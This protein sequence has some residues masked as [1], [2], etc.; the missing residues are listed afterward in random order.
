MI[1]IHST[2]RARRLLPYTPPAEV[3]PMAVTVSAQT[4][5]DLSRM[6]FALPLM[7]IQQ[8]PLPPPFSKR[9]NA[10]VQFLRPGLG[11]CLAEFG[12]VLVEFGDALPGLLVLGAHGVEIYLRYLAVGL[13]DDPA[14]DSDA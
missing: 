6:Q 1:I 2:K 7:S 8:F 13:A 5:I 4:A 14:A 12:E 11:A 10:A 9:R 3:D